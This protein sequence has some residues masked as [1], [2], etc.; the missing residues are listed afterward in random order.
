M[1]VHQ[2]TQQGVTKGIQAKERSTLLQLNTYSTEQI[3]KYIKYKGRRLNSKSPARKEIH[4]D[5]SQVFL[6]W[7]SNLHF[8]YVHCGR[9]YL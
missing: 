5:L 6:L 8:V 2:N 7:Q 1:R 4:G 3:V 9:K